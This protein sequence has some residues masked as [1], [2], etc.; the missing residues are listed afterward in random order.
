MNKD[1]SFAISGR[2][3]GGWKLKAF[4]ENVQFS[5]KIF[6]LL[7]VLVGESNI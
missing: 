1:S 2:E 3:T 7:T 4:M 6:K 5:E